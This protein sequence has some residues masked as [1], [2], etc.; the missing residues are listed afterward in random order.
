[1]NPILRFVL[2]VII[3]G[4]GGAAIAYL[5]FTY[6]G[7]KWIDGKFSERL[8]T[9]KHELNLQ[10]EQYRFEINSLFN[11][12]TKIHEKEFDVLP[13][14][15]SKLQ[16]AIGIVA[17]FTSPVQMYPDLNRMNEAQIE[18]TLAKTTLTV[19]QK[20]DIRNAD[21][22]NQ[23][24]IKTIFWYELN[25]AR[26]NA[27]EFHNYLVYNKIFLSKDLFDSFSKVDARLS[28]ALMEREVQE[29][30]RNHELVA[31]DFI[32]A[33]E[34]IQ[35]IVETIEQQIQRRLHYTDVV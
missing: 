23:M 1:M 35:S 28:K 17:N 9:F 7:K 33:R 6:L 24:Y 22:K 12:I 20:N 30:S 10:M 31:T 3:A 25:E 14:A 8:E 18:E 32:K 26:R 21:D 4:G 16:N 15:W 11:R 27:G 34:E 13:T 19:S 2:D 5:I 29:R